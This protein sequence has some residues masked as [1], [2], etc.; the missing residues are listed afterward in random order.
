M[1]SRY[2]EEESGREGEGEAV[3]LCGAMSKQGLQLLHG[4][5]KRHPQVH[6]IVRA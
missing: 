5:Q 3:L 6:V 1:L 4:E 2:G